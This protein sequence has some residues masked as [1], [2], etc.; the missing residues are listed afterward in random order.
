MRVRV[1][2]GDEQGY[3]GMQ[4]AT[5]RCS[6]ITSDALYIPLSWGSARGEKRSCI[7]GCS[8]KVAMLIW[9][10]KS[11]FKLVQYLGCI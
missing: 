3:A 9:I 8:V 4:V 2:D 1:R 7:D 6:N 11:A 10:M 5:I